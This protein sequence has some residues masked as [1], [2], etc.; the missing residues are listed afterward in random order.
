[1]RITNLALTVL[2]ATAAVSTEVRASSRKNTLSSY[3]H[4]GSLTYALKN[5]AIP[6][7]CSTLV[8]FFI[9]QAVNRDKATEASQRDV[10]HCNIMKRSKDIDSYYLLCK[11]ALFVLG[12]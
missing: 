12:R 7:A 2:T 1:M 5:G 9:T 11:L 4:C 8:A 6:T 10:R 3:A